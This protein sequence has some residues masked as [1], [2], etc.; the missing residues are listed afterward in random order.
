VLVG[1]FARQA[2][3]PGSLHELS[4]TAFVAAL[5]LVQEQLSSK[6]HNDRQKA[7]ELAAATA[8][9]FRGLCLAGA[10]GPALLIL[11]DDPQDSRLAYAVMHYC[12]VTARHK[13][14]FHQ[15]P[16]HQGRDALQEFYRLKGNELKLMYGSYTCFLK[17]L[18]LQ[19]VKRDYGE[20]FNSDCGRQV[21]LALSRLGGRLGGLAGGKAGYAAGLGP[22]FAKLAPAQKE[23]HYQAAGKAAYAAALG[24]YLAGLTPAKKE[25]HYK[26]AYKA[27][28]GP[29]VAKLTLAQS[30]EQHQAAGKVGGKAGGPKA[31]TAKQRNNI[32]AAVAAG[33]NG[34]ALMDTCPDCGLFAVKLD[35]KESKPTTSSIK[36]CR[37]LPQF[38]RTKIPWRRIPDVLGKF[39][40]DAGE[41]CPKQCGDLI[42]E[43]LFGQQ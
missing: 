24:P 27:G 31:A 5:V 37:G 30:K 28:L 35:E 14:P 23:E 3:P 42:V 12:A 22:Y 7:I 41:Y 1:R 36:K 34:W 43:L 4:G 20:T 19:E 25:E 11:S 33:A 26:A 18:V 21:H 13:L 8:A 9:Q 2:I 6:L 38:N 17:N 15:G 40:T 10:D 39:P 29:Y 32:R 16:L